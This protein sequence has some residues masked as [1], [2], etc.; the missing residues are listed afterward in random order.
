[1]GRL[2]VGASHKKLLLTTTM[3][4]GAFAGYGRRAYGA[5]APAGGSTYTCSGANLTG[6]TI[7]V[8]DADVGTVAGFSVDTG[9]NFAINIEGDGTLFYADDYASPLTATVTALRIVS[10]DSA[11]S[12]TVKTNGQ[13]TGSVNG[14]YAYNSGGTFLHVTAN[15]SVYGTAYAGILAANLGSE[16]TSVTTGAGTKLSGATGIIARNEGGALKIT[17]D[18]DVYGTSGAGISAS[19]FGSSLTVTTGADTYVKGATDGIVASNYGNGELTIEANGDVTGTGGAGIYAKNFGTSLTVTTGTGS[20]V[21]GSYGIRTSNVGSEALKIT[22]NGDVTGTGGAGIFAENNGTSLTVMTGDLTEVAGTTFG[23]AAINHNGTDVTVTTGKGSTV[24][25]VDYGI[26]A[27]AYGSGKLSIETHGDVSGT[28]RGIR[29]L[30]ITDGGTIIM[31]DEGTT[32]YGGSSGIYAFNSGYGSLTVEANGDVTGMTHNGIQAI[33]IGSD[34]DL[35]I[36]TGEG[37]LVEG[38]MTG[39]RAANSGSGAL[40]VAAN[41]Y[42]TGGK[43]GMFL[44]GASAAITVTVASTGNVTSAGSTADDFGIQISSGAANIIVAGAVTGGAGGAIA[45]ALCGCADDRL[46]LQT[47]GSID[48][49]VLAGPGVDSLVLGGTGSDSLDV[50][51]IGDTAQYQGFESFAKE[52][53]GHWTLTGSNTSITEWTVDGGVLSVNA[54]MSSAVFAVD[55]GTLGGPGIIGGLFASAGSTV[56]PG[57]SIGTLTVNGNA[58]LAAGSIFE[59]EVNDAGQSDLLVVNG[60]VS[61]TGAI[62]NV[63]ADPGSY[64]AATTYLIIDNDLAD[65]VTGT[66]GPVTTN[67]AFLTPSVSYT[68]NTGNDVALTLTRNTTNFTDVAQTPNQ[69]AVAGALGTLPASDPLVQAL[70][71]QTSAGALQAF[72]ALS[73]EL[74]ASV[75]GML[76][77]ESRFVRDAIFARLLQ[78]SYGGGGGTSFAAL[79]GGGPSVAALSGAP[80][81]GLG[82]GSGGKGSSVP[83]GTGLVAWTQGFGSWGDFKSDGNAASADRT[84]GGFVS[85]VDAGFGGSWRAGV[86]GGYTQTNA[87]VDARGSSADIE[88][89]HLAAYGGGGLGPLALRSGAAWTWHEIETDRT[90]VFPGFFQRANA[91]YDGDSGQVFGEAAL[92]LGSGATALEAFGRFS[93]VHVSTGG[94]TENGGI[95][96]LAASGNDQNVTFST[97]GTRT[98]TVMFIDGMHVT[99]HASAAWQHAFGDVTADMALAF[100]GNGA[101]FAI[102]GVPIAR[103]SALI[104]AGLDFKIAPDA[105]L[106]V[107]YNGQLASDVQDHGISGRLDWRF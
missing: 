29:A 28:F 20:Q 76:V 49:L 15:G 96:A 37:T 10:N 2:G 51:D 21:Q 56:A 16:G 68:A 80:M 66:F 92:P 18:G 6:Q 27:Y 104:E 88:S 93:Y 85:G 59:V 5:C 78:A 38:G 14:I 44:S 73:G 101:G 71:G 43:D 106:G 103:N 32:T 22:A 47:G 7:L 19:N 39:I 4:V 45:F 50:G 84:L 34:S 98:A 62:L 105:T 77:D 61:L 25:G 12:I 60:T 24:E 63:L 55:S 17:A 79:A 52:G 9:D 57:N 11:G 87:S 72:D 107:S 90:I 40:T 13:L 94:F 75:A 91:S 3:L 74:H 97:L 8:D 83:G 99:P 42:V 69:K 70:I 81:M 53:T 65:P 26:Y 54:D 33:N 35:T 23:I 67:L 31:T 82:M 58:S 86:A 95:A 1:M 30:S 89:Y 36:T 64:A 46:E 48:G 41:G 102:A 100:A